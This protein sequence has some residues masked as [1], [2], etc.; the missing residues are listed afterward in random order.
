M[1][2]REIDL[3]GSNELI[4]CIL[5]YILDVFY[6][7]WITQDVLGQEYNLGSP[8]GESTDNCFAYAAGAAL[9]TISAYD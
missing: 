5:A 4:V 9:H 2:R 7:E 8:G 6:N 3:L 1:Q